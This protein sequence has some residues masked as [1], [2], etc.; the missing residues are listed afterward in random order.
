LTDPVADM[1][2][3]EDWIAYALGG[4]HRRPR[5]AQRILEAVYEVLAGQSTDGVAIPVRE[6]AL[7]AGASPSSV[8]SALERLRDLGLLRRTGGGDWI[9]RPAGRPGVRL[10]YLYQPLWPPVVS[11][12]PAS[13]D[14][15]SGSTTGF[16]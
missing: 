13:G 16:P 9:A 12:L 6:V 10:P 3:A 11:R 8:A 2:R 4:Y 5:K 15:T 14:P 7:R 1:P